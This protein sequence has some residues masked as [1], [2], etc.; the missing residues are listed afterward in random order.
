M[1]SKILIIGMVMVLATSCKKS[2]L[3]LQPYNAFPLSAATS[4]E[5]NLYTAINGV[6]SNLRSTDLF[7]RM[8]GIKGDLMGDN[9]W[10]KLSNS[11]RFLE[12][13]DYNI[14]VANGN[15]AAL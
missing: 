1:K 2:F 13:N 5:G 15:A 10:V 8:V 11:G 12:F 4:N 14:T 3:D 7:G 9:T 6:Y